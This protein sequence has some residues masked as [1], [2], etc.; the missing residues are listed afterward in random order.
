MLQIRPNK[1][2]ANQ[3]IPD[4]SM[5]CSKPLSL[6]PSLPSL[7][8]PLSPHPSP[9][10][11]DRPLPSLTEKL[12]L[13]SFTMTCSCFSAASC[14]RSRLR[15]AS[16]WIQIQIQGQKGMKGKVSIGSSPLQ[17]LLSCL[18][19]AHKAALHVTQNVNSTLA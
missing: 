12:A 3:N 16:P 14:R 1:E 13:L 17:L 15:S 19:Q 10:A 5:T 8:T 6:P 11:A 9:V 4:R 2:F 7:L 18:V